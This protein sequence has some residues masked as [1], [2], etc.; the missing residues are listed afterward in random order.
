MVPPPPHGRGRRAALV[1]ILTHLGTVLSMRLLMPGGAGGRGV[2]Y[3]R[4]HLLGYLITHHDLRGTFLTRATLAL[5]IFH[6]LRGGGMFEHYLGSHGR[7]E[8]R[9][10]NIQK[11]VKNDYETIS[12]NFFTKVKIVP[13]GLKMAKFSIFC[14]CQR[15]F[16]KA[17]II[18]GTIIARA[19]PKT[20]FERKL[21]SPYH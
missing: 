16:R 20:A 10:K 7:R 2:A 21:Y 12:V 4:R 19:N 1:R 8:K 18:S 13:P 3:L 17:S 9:K 5:Q 15:S 14:D 6:H 11:L